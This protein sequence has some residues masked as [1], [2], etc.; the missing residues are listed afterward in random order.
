MELAGQ[1][2]QERQV[3]MVTHDPKV[4][5]R[6]KRTIWVQEGDIPSHRKGAPPRRRAQ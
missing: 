2:H 1:L 5:Q 6:A 4:A 3:M